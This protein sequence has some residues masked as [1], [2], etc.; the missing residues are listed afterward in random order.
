M[1][2]ESFIA[3]RLN[4][5]S[6]CSFFQASEEAF[7]QETVTSCLVKEAYS[8]IEFESF[9]PRMNVEHIK[10][11]LRHCVYRNWMA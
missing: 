10:I 6:A 2:V 8:I 1:P 9:L 3:L 4:L 7:L 5:M 11:S